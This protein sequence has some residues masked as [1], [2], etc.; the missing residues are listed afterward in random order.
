MPLFVQAFALAWVGAVC[1]WLA[2]RKDLDSA[3]ANRTKWD[4]PLQGRIVR[5][6]ALLVAV[7]SLALLGALVAWALF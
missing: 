2:S 4:I 3:R 5:L 6:N 1:I 7:S